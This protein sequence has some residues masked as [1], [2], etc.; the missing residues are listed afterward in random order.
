MARAIICDCCGKQ[1]RYSSGE[2][3]SRLQ[4]DG[5]TEVLTFGLGQSGLIG[6]AGIR[7]ELEGLLC[8]DCY[9]RLVEIIRGNLAI[10]KDAIGR[11]AEEKKDEEPLQVYHF[12]EPTQ[13]YPDEEEKQQG[14]GEDHGG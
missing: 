14:E 5:W 11:M 13:S 1:E 9:P 3:L 2:R 10:V 4:S 7:P 8:S 12:D 6:Q